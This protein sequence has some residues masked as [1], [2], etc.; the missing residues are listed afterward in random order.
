MD[1]ARFQPD[2]MPGRLVRIENGEQAF[3][4]NPLPP[5]LEL[6]A[7][8]FLLLAQA[9]EEIA[10]VRGLTDPLNLPDPT[11]LLRPLQLEESLRSS[12]LEGTF[13]EDEELLLFELDAPEAPEAANRAD[14]TREVANLRQTL[15]LSASLISQ[16]AP[17]VHD[18]RSMHQLLLRHVRGQD[19]SP[20]EFRAGQVFIG[21][22]HR[23]IPPPG[24]LVGDAMQSLLAYWANPKDDLPALV[25]AILAHYQ[26]EAIHPFRDGNGR[27]GR[28]LL[29]LMIAQ[30]SSLSAPWIHL[31]AFFEKHRREY[32][33]TLFDVSASGAWLDWVDFCLRAV[34]TQAKDTADRCREL[35][36]LRKQWGNEIQQAN[37]K[38]RTL[39]LIDRL[40]SL[41]VIDV[42]TARELLD[43]K[44][45]MTART[46]LDQLVKLN[47]LEPIPDRFPLTFRAP[48][49]TRIIFRR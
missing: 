16:R 40:L 26:F 11:V 23:F 49:V 35:L 38:A 27:V 24:H 45:Y 48:D 2:A 34:M 10:V 44:S 14:Q 25:R 20:G 19:K 22:D 9:R 5:R 18:V 29:T 47:I 43:V 28:A 13:A 39:S 46:D 3:V 32:F 12:S 15:Q 37:L 42:E 21:A 4:P 8:I 33:D 30:C 36:Q 41:P 17:T 31:S 6:T 7:D 1:T